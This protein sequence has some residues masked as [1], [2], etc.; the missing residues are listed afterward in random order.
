MKPVAVSDLLPRTIDIRRGR[1]RTVELSLEHGTL[2]ARVPRRIS[3]KE[4]DPLLGTLRRQLWESLHD[5]YVLDDTALH[6]RARRVAT[7]RLFDLD[8]PPFEIGFSRRQ[9]KRW[10]SCRVGPDGGHIRI[11]AALLGHPL[12]VLDDVLLHELIHLRVPNHGPDFHRLMDRSPDR[13]RA[14]GYL[15]AVETLER[16]GGEL[17]AR[18][19]DAVE[20]EEVE[21]RSPEAA[22]PLFEDRVSPPQDPGTA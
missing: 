13:E 17:R 19:R 3:R 6:R 10:G 15:E 11:S 1:R 16:F 21:A 9:K 18:L 22:L 2:V 14:R 4:L 20:S 5:R 12:W 8:L 7:Q